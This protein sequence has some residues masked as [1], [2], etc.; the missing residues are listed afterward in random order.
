MTHIN[1]MIILGFLLVQSVYSGTF[2]T[3]NISGYT[4]LEQQRSICKTCIPLIHPLD[5]NDICASFDYLYDVTGCSQEY[6]LALLHPS[7]TFVSCEDEYPVLCTCNEAVCQHGSPSN[8][9]S[10]NPVIK[11][12]S[13]SPVHSST[14]KPSRGPSITPTRSPS[15]S[16]NILP[17]IPPTFIP[18]H[19]P[20]KTPSF[21]P[22]TKPSINP[23]NEPSRGPSQS[24][25]KTPTNIPSK[26]PSI[27]PS[28]SPTNIPSGVPSITPT[29]SPTNQP[30]KGPSINPTRSP[31]DSPTNEPSR[32][33][34]I[35]P[36]HSPSKSPSTSSPSDSPTYTPSGVPSITP[37]YS[38]TNE[39]TNQPSRGP[40]IAPSYSPSRSPTN[41][42]SKSP[43]TSSPSISP[44]HIPSHVPS[45][46]PTSSPT[47]SPNMLP[48]NPP[49]FA[50]SRNP[51]KTP[52]KA[53][54]VG[55]TNNPSTKPS[56]SPTTQPSKNPSTQPTS[57]PS[58]QPTFIPSHVPSINPSVSPSKQPTFTP[59]GGPSV[60][61]TYSP[62]DSPT[63]K[64]SSSPT[65]AP[66]NVPTFAP[67]KDP[68]LAPTKT[69]TLVP[70]KNPTN[71][72]TPPTF[73]PTKNP[74]KTPTLAPS[75]APTSSPIP[76]LPNDANMYVYKTQLSIPDDPAE[77]RIEIAVSTNALEIAAGYPRVP[78][79]SPILSYVSTF[80]RTGAYEWTRNPT[81]LTEGSERFGLRVCMNAH[82][83]VIV[84]GYAQTGGNVLKIFQRNTVND[85]WTY[86]TTLSI[87]GWTLPSGGTGGLGLSCALNADGTILVASVRD[88]GAV[89]WG[90]IRTW[91][92]VG[93]TWTADASVLRVS[94]TST[95]DRGGTCLD[96]SA[97]G[98]YLIVGS[99]GLSSGFGRIGTYSRSG[100]SWSQMQLFGQ[101]SAPL[102]GN[103]TGAIS[104]GFACAIRADGL[105]LVGGAYTSDSNK[106]A[107]VIFERLSA[108]TFRQVIKGTITDDNFGYSVSLFDK[109]LAV[110]SYGYDSGKGRVSIFE[111]TGTGGIAYYDLKQ[112]I[113]T[114]EPATGTGFGGY[115]VLS[116]N[117]LIIGP[118]D[119]GVNKIWVYTRDH[120]FEFRQLLTLNN[121]PAIADLPI[122]CSTDGVDIVGAYIRTPTTSPTLSYL[123]TYK[124]SGTNT[125]TRSPTMLT[126]SDSNRFGKTLC[127]S[128]NG[129]VIVTAYPDT[130]G[131]KA[132][133]FRR[134]DSSSGY[135]REAVLT[136]NGWT[137]ANGNEG[138]G[139][140]CALNHAGTRLLISVMDDGADDW[141]SVRQFLYNTGTW[142]EDATQLRSPTGT[143]QVDRFGSCL[144]VTPDDKMLV[145]GVPSFV[146]GIVYTYR[147]ISGQ[148]WT[149]SGTLHGS[150]NGDISGNFGVSCDTSN[151]YGVVGS[152]AYNS[153]RGGVMIFY[154]YSDAGYA[155]FRQTIKNDAGNPTQYFGQSVSITDD[156]LAVSIHTYDS[157]RG[158]V[159]VYRNENDVFVHLQ[160]VYAS[161][162][163]ASERFGVHVK[164]CNQTLVVSPGLVGANRIWVYTL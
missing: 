142:T 17:T 86:K 65:L 16:P 38:P 5:D 42:P 130:T 8:A 110:G 147:R 150:H 149:Y 37:T 41:E 155:E 28:H 129:N 157:S 29:H 144:S 153:N 74:T 11:G 49:T 35:G 137:N 135:T 59:S 90:S 68:T 111:N 32:G 114:P 119:N 20:S 97:D 128:G 120:G 131:N 109:F 21:A 113:Y 158:R 117:D 92:Y 77:N 67:T 12:P 25:S 46:Q 81:K 53:P 122:A 115:P 66:T 13:I 10:A 126:D 98:T 132:I 60:N 105:I 93:T 124:Q 55:P 79:A 24:P 30:S 100:G 7:L 73:A 70:T 54:S 123:N 62:S 80:R 95:V 82:A 27:T 163:T 134:P 18:S 89:N 107:V 103:L 57:S 2:K 143:S 154:L 94:A 99:P 39:P 71:T 156:Y 85:A 121:A 162:L 51:T 133:V 15:I 136:P 127:M 118:R 19:N 22:S 146:G 138:F 84:S 50:P 140:A 31:S 164:L 45:I 1:K 76:V 139:E 102:A 58:N 161:S 104:L 108:W 63:N 116:G 36:S 9:P 34:S 64:P 78:T 152:P 151:Y 75:G 4:L 56:V 159:E 106:G 145:V 44:T 125:W 47:T 101:G 160:Y 6:G 33:P 43:S 14:N 40:S 23:T 3:P 69:P 112:I 87:A 141:G 48:T 96:L 148:T 52:S 91:T 72:P 61:P 83:T 26:G 88:D